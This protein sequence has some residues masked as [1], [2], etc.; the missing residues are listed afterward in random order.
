MLRFRPALAATLRPGCWT[1][2]DAERV[3]LVTAK[4]S[5]AIT[6]QVSM[7]LRAVLWWK[8]RRLL[9]RVRCSLASF[10][11]ARRRLPDPGWQLATTRCSVA[12]PVLRTCGCVGLI[13][14]GLIETW[15]SCCAGVAWGLPESRGAFPTTPTTTTPA[16]AARPLWPAQRGEGAGG[17]AGGGQLLPAP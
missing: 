13:G 3:I 12:S 10:R 2:P 7:R 11:L 9:A 5:T 16:A 8:S 17:A 1:V 14:S 15:L 4:F 6:S